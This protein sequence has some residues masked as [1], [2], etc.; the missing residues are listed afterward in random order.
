MCG[1][2]AE[3]GPHNGWGWSLSGRPAQQHVAIYGN[4]V[5]YVQQ[6]VT[7]RPVGSS[8]RCLLDPPGLPQQSIGV[9]VVAGVVVGAT[10]RWMSMQS[11]QSR[12]QALP[13]YS[14]ADQTARFARHRHDASP[15]VL[16]IESVFDPQQLAGKR[17]L[18]T[19]ANRGLGLALIQVLCEAGAHAVAICRNSSPELEALRPATLV[20]GIDVTDDSAMDK[21]VHSLGAQAL[22]MIINNA[23]YFYGPA[24]TLSSLAFDEEKKM[25]D[26]CALGPLR[27]TAALAR[28]N[29]LRHGSKVI[30][31]TSQ[32]GSV[33]WRE[34]QNPQGHDYG[35]HASKAAANMISQLLALEL[36]DRDIA[37]GIFHPG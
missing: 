10:L 21:L 6:T 2:V 27:V 13:K 29:L 26:I 32:G 5:D 24:E 36:R 7:F 12:V 1:F 16:H 8:L 17:V 31:I 37:V 11:S 34:V 30:N 22:D 25:F 15:R 33:A 4:L 14:I 19:G 9:G 18:V 23:G 20:E 28:A 35:H 3:V